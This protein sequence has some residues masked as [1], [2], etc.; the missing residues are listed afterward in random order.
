MAGPT[1]RTPVDVVVLLMEERGIF[2]EEEPVVMK[3]WDF[4][5]REEYYAMH[6]FFLTNRG[7]NLVITRLDAYAWTRCCWQ[8][9]GG[10]PSLLFKA[11]HTVLPGS[12][13]LLAMHRL[14][15]TAA[16]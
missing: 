15:G 5:A 11:A 13:S 2:N 10:N 1:R 14:A 9:G 7:L 12:G 16:G 3:M 6:H 8:A 4:G